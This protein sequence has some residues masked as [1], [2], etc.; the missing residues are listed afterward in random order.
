MDELEIRANAMLAEVRQ[1]RE[2]Y[3]NRCASLSADLALANGQIAALTAQ[4][5]K[6]TP[7]ANSESSASAPAAS[8]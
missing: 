1:Q 5:K 2:F 7:A 6:L 8:G 4:V 3:A